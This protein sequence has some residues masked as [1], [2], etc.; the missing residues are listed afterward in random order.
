MNSTSNIP[1]RNNQYLTGIYVATCLIFACVI[2]AI[3]LVFVCVEKLTKRRGLFSDF[4]KTNDGENIETFEML[5]KPNTL[6]P[7]LIGIESV[8][9]SKKNSLEQPRKISMIPLTS[10]VSQTSVENTKQ[11]RKQSKKAFMKRE[12]NLSLPIV[13][14]KSVDSFAKLRTEKRRYQSDSSNFT[15]A[16]KKEERKQLSLLKK[17]RNLSLDDENTKLKK[18]KYQN[19][20]RRVSRL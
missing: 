13:R 20:M 11:T 14:S 17:E 1:T 5:N 15:H 4:T 18:K 2:F 12:V 10:M 6:S 9:S 8:T 16:K 7:N 3:Y 19:Q